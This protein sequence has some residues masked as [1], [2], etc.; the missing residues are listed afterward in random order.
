[1]EIGNEGPI[2]AGKHSSPE[3]GAEE[4]RN[5]VMIR[6]KLLGPP[7][8]TDNDG[9]TVGSV[10]ARTREFALLVYLAAR[11]E[12]GHRRDTLLALLWPELDEK[13]ARKALRQ[14]LYELRRALGADLIHGTGNE[15]IA[16]DPKRLWCDA[17][18]FALRLERGDDEAALRLYRGPFLEGFHLSGSPT[19][20]RW[21]DVECRRLERA[22]VA[23]CWRLVDAATAHDPSA[24]RRWAE[25][26]IAL[27]PFDERGFRRYLELLRERGELATALQAYERFAHR[28][29]AELDTR[30][31]PET[32]ALVEPMRR[33][34]VRRT[35]EPIAAPVPPRAIPQ[36]PEV[37]RQPARGRLRTAWTVGS[38]AAVVGIVLLL[39]MFVRSK[40]AVPLA[41]EA[42]PIRSVLVLPLESL[43]GNGGPDF[44]ADGLTEAMI[45]EL[46]QARSLT[47]FDPRTSMRLKDT[48]DPIPAILARVPAD[49][50]LEGSALQVDGRVRITVRLIDGRSGRLIW[51]QAYEDDLRDVLALQKRV[52]RSVTDE[53]GVELTGEED[54]LLSNATA[55]T[56]EAYDAYLRGRYWFAKWTGEGFREAT[57]AFSEAFA[58]DPQFAAAYAGHAYAL[59]HLCSSGAAEAPSVAVCQQRVEA[60]ALRALEL[61]D[62]LAEAHVTLGFIRWWGHNRDLPAAEEALRTAVRL[63]PGYA[64]AHSRYGFVLATL[65]R[66]EEAVAAFERAYRLDP[67]SPDRAGFLALA[68]GA[69][70]RYAEAERAARR[71]IAMEPDFSGNHAWF[72]YWVLGPQGRYEEAIA[73]LRRA[74]EL[75]G[76]NSPVGFESMLGCLL[77]RAG[78]TE[79]AEAILD[80]LLNDPHADR[81]PPSTIATVYLGLG[82][83]E[84]A[85]DWME[86]AYEE[87]WGHVIYLGISPYWKPLHG[88]PRFERLARRIGLGDL[89]AKGA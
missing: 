69:A 66:H 82:K 18:E 63:N 7:D 65:G 8:L 40:T 71:A 31:A 84:Q 29:A 62:Q 73:S 74:I 54:A 28:L 55:V 87:G 68:L 13:R 50:V 77:G 22:A 25:R 27:S 32:V 43:A 56:A 20:E 12:T 89:P 24:A 59:S 88:H 53:I 33:E 37:R 30:P 3:A 6:L 75:S 78:R 44:F 58:I 14:S 79:E 81:I 34:P 52:A 60:S 38:T 39:M 51:T 4:E 42:D 5:D 86:R 11:P 64:E 76:P 47:V 35:S 1:M 80:R 46:G 67:L 41:P 61:D 45:T 2:F 19:F 21:L 70:E 85:L 72:G 17:V 57:R 15:L 48:E 9:T 10:L 83:E 49:A 16:V 26:A 36:T 23:A